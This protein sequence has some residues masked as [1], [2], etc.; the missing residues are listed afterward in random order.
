MF[1][2]KNSGLK[3]LWKVIAIVFEL[4][5]TSSKCFSRTKALKFGVIW[6]VIQT[7]KK[8]LVSNEKNYLGV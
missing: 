3:S 5:K 2:I 6:K 8:S 4:S 7:K 1:T